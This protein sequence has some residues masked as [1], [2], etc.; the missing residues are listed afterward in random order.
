VAL[1]FLNLMKMGILLV[2]L[3]Y[4][5]TIV[6]LHG[7]IIYFYQ[8]IL[9]ENDLFFFYFC[10]FLSNAGY[11]GDAKTYKC[12]TS[13]VWYPVDSILT[14]AGMYKFLIFCCASTVRPLAQ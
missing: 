8:E 14:C 5:K 6:K 9:F 11:N 1:I 10:L 2:L 13:G 7:K 12:G 4:M 3:H